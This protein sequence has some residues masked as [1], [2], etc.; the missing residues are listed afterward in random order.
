MTW[1][2]PCSTS[3][4]QWLRRFC[5]L[6]CV[7]AGCCSVQPLR[8]QNIDLEKPLHSI[9]EDITAFAFGPDGRIVYSVRQLLKTK[10]YDLQRD[11]IWIQDANGKRRR[12]I[13]GDK[14]AYSNP[15]FSY[16]V[17]SFRWAPDGHTL[18]ANLFVSLV[19]DDSGGT[20]DTQMAMLFE[21]SG[22]QLKIA[23]SKDFL[24]E[25]TDPGWL[26]D[27]STVVYLSEAIKPRV[28]FNMFA[29]RY[30]VERARPIFEGRTFLGAAW[31]P[32]MSVA[33][34]VERDRNL[35]GPP[36]LQRLNIALD[37]D[38]ELA[39]LD[40]FTGGLS[41]SPSGKLCA[42]YIDNEVLEVR[43]LASPNRVA[44]VRIGLGVFQWSPDEDRL[45]LKRAPEK[46][47]GDLV[48]IDLPPL[49]VPPSGKS[50]V[51]VQPT[52]VPLFHNLAFREFTISPDGRFLAL[53]APGKHNL[54]VFSLPR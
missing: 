40:S 31:F 36:R 46:K 19:T 24:F 50:A 15:L 38:Q 12:L 17:D 33:L 23:D 34:G 32:R 11:D 49:A 3:R 44:R 14:L 2:C 42:Y 21:D 26:T 29:F 45:L 8:A 10:K 16:S 9:N 1:I 41:I 6:I 5:S 48:W 39:T 35:S 27:N 37:S 13:Q 47:S 43:D 20:R 18:L 28:L 4:S 7:L 22:K 53:V 51:I 30:G 54:L 25:A 52:P